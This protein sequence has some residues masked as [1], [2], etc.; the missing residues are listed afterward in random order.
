M[1]ALPEREKLEKHSEEFARQRS[2]GLTVSYLAEK[3]GVPLKEA[4]SFLIEKE[5]LVGEQVDLELLRTLFER[6]HALRN[7]ICEHLGITARLLDE[8]LLDQDPNLKS[9]VWLN[10]QQNKVPVYLAGLMFAMN[11]LSVPSV[12]VLLA[13]LITFIFFLRSYLYHDQ[14]QT[15]LSA[16]LRIMEEV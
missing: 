7:E 10:H 5:I 13:C 14:P 16:V 6:D 11:P 8:L 12:G 1:Q 2:K 4:M 15:T 9:R 3:A